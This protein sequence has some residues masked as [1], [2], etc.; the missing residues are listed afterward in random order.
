M[1]A[2]FTG[3]VAVFKD[4]GLSVATVQRAEISHGQ[5]TN[6]FWVNL[7]LGAALA[8][9]IAGA[10]PLLARFYGDPRLE[11][12]TAVS[13]IGFLL[14]GLTIQ[15]QALLRRQ[16]RFTSL[17][18]VEIAAMLASVSVA[19]SLAWYGAHYWSLVF[20]QLAAVATTAVAVWMLS[21]WRPGL[22]TR[23][24]GVR[25]MLL[26]G[27]NLTAFN[28]INYWARNLDN[29]LIGR[30]WGAA[31]LGLYSRAYQLLL[32]PIDQITA[33]ITAVA[34]PALS[35]LVD[36]PERYRRAYVRILA[37]LAMVTMPLM[38]FMIVTSDWMVRVVLGS[39]WMGVSPIFAWLG[40]AGLLQPLSST[41]TW[42]LI[43]QGRA[44]EMFRWGAMGNTIIVASICAGLP[45]GALGVAM[46]YSICNVLVVQPFLLW[47][48]CRKGPIRPGDVLRAI[49]PAVWA[50]LCLLAVL[51][52]LRHSL[53]AVDAPHGL[54]LAA[55]VATLVVPVA[56]LALP[57]GRLVLL[58]AVTSLRGI[59]FPRRSP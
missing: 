22:P 45:W 2:V 48:V 33:P 59:V 30:V 13:A 42:L 53:G 52:L 40:L 28:V 51:S 1:V 17:A 10:A 46:S 54:A 50:S 36:S 47:F 41:G 18:V 14:S 11:A 12:I 27:G 23:R 6:L 44:H 24:S 8:L 21:R 7:T 29:L 38:V 57:S 35:R 20:N 39:Q 31:Q 32:L 26:F 9:V 58:D 56:F 43:S 34:V 5:V 49:A 37:K 4:L 16:M 3:F 19:V 15:H 25:S 55:A